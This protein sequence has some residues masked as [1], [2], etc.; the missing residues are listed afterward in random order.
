MQKK[1]PSFPLLVPDPHE[2]ATPASNQV[3]L[4]HKEV[5]LK[6]HKISS[7]KL[8]EKKSFQRSPSLTFFVTN[9]IKEK[10]NYYQ[11][12]DNRSKIVESFKTEH[13]K[14]IEILEKN[15]KI[16]LIKI[17][18]I[19]RCQKDP[20]EFGSQKSIQQKERLVTIKK[21]LANRRFFN[22]IKI[23][24]DKISEL[25]FNTKMNVQICPNVEKQLILLTR[26]TS[27]QYEDALFQEFRLQLKIGDL[28]RNKRPRKQRNLQSNALIYRS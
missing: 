1:I 10:E 28:T 3:E 24:E 17:K 16:S 13:V 2:S 27:S 21:V 15:D 12:I 20:A 8:F 5:Q 19:V 4:K 14:Q 6:L 25:L 18:K 26:P 23:P 22:N 9:Q 7:S 11:I